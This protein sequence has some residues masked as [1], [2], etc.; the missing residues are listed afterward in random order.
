MVLSLKANKKRIVALLIL[1]LVI[2]GGFIIIPK[3]IEEPVSYYGETSAQRIEFLQSFGY[4]IY[5]EPI[6]SRNV[7]IPT[8]FNEVY[9]TYNVM[10]KT[11]DFD[12]ESFKGQECTQYVYL[13]ENY[14]D[15]DGEIHATLLVYEGVII[16][17]DVSCAE[18]DGF[19]HGFAMDS[20]HYGD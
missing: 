19:M 17:G 14:P 10:Q 4:E 3:L 7:I 13:V 2:I 15:V 6:D 20:A 11:Q 12:L 5:E 1:V 18:I 8:E 16:G 9:E